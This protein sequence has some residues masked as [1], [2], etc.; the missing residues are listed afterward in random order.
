MNTAIKIGIG[1]TAV[2]I[3]YRLLQ[4]NKLAANVTVSLSKIR[5]QKVNL[6]GVEIAVTARVN[7]PSNVAATIVNPV[8]RLWNTKSSLIAESP[9]TGRKFLIAANKQSDVGEILLPI[10]WGALLPLLGIKNI[11]SIISLFSKDG[12]KGLLVS[13]NSPISMTVLMQVDG[14]TVETPKT[15][16]NK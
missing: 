8:V 15:V 3:G 2:F 6:S 10:S 11:A 7:N 16:I 9:A 14:M 12:T 5:V 1:A 13:F 4:L